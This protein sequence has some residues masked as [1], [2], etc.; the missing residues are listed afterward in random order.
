MIAWRFHSLLKLYP[1]LTLSSSSYFRHRSL[2]QVLMSKFYVNFTFSREVI[3]TLM[4]SSCQFHKITEQT[5]FSRNCQIHIQGTLLQ[6][7]SGKRN[8]SKRKMTS[9]EKKMADHLG[10]VTVFWEMLS[11]YDNPCQLHTHRTLLPKFK[12][13]ISLRRDIFGYSVTQRWAFPTDTTVILF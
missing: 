12:N 2:I 13:K 9:L 11:F 10:R 3:L 5:Q 4:T 1:F 6:D 8:V 7:I